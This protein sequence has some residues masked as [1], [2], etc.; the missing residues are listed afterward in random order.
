M[1]IVFKIDIIKRYI[2][3]TFK[4]KP[5]KYTDP[6]TKEVIVIS[7]EEQEQMLEK[8]IRINIPVEQ[9]DDNSSTQ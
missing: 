8:G 6:K 4:F 3:S 1:A 5:I 9:V 7:P 2:M